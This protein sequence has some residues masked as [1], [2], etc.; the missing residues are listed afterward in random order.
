MANVGIALC[1]CHDKKLRNFAKALEYCDIALIQQKDFEPALKLR[2]SLT[3]KNNNLK[4]TAD[5]KGTFSEAAG[6]VV[7][8]F[9]GNVI[10]SILTSG[11]DD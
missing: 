8:E 5:L 1:Y 2:K 10:N 6:N 7:G 9:F 4:P 11:Q 3:D